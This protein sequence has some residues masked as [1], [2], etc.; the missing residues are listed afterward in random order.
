MCSRPQ[1]HFPPS[2]MVPTRAV[3][4]GHWNPGMKKS[5]IRGEIISGNDKPGE[6]E[7][8]ARV[9]RKE[10]YR[11]CNIPTPS[12]AICNCAL[13][14]MHVSAVLDEFRDR[15]PLKNRAHGLTFATVGPCFLMR[16]WRPRM[17]FSWYPDSA[18]RRKSMAETRP[19][20]ARGCELGQG[21]PLRLL[22]KRRME[23][24]KRS[25]SKASA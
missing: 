5:P 24:K 20:T 21:S 6:S 25:A 16:S 9:T 1:T 4:C 22:L 17:T 11:A 8:I 3:L 23:V 7:R 13:I 2:P 10:T 18:W 12:T 15:D 14:S 19:P